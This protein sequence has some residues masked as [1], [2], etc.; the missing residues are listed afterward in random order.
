MDDQRIETRAAFGGVNR[1]DRS[2]V[3]CI[4]CEAVNRFGWYR[5]D[6]ARLDQR[7]GLGNRR[8]AVGANAGIK[9]GFCAWHGRRYSGA[10]LILPT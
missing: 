3:G 10:E 4:A 8:S 9:T 6:S 2:A 7:C 1:G 5:D